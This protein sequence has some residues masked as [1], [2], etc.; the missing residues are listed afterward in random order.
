MHPAIECCGKTHHT[1]MLCNNAAM[2]NSNKALCCSLTT[3][4]DVF[5]LYL[6]SQEAEL[7]DK[8]YC[9]LPWSYICLLLFIQLVSNLPTGDNQT[10]LAVVP[11]LWL[12]SFM[13]CYVSSYCPTEVSYSMNYISHWS[14]Q[15]K[16]SQFFR[17]IVQS[18]QMHW[19]AKCKTSILMLW[20]FNDVYGLFCSTVHR[21]A[22]H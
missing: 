10:D 18:S 14:L 16:D 15:K 6:I 8:I 2:C 17:E 5:F 1:E 12:F 19:K 20:A 4:T 21:Q 11:Q 3:A 13:N 9:F 7:D 22:I